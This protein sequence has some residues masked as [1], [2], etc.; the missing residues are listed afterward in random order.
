M[1]KAVESRY[2]LLYEYRAGKFTISAPTRNIKNP[3]D[4][5]EFLNGQKR[6]KGMTEDQISQLR[7]YCDRRW[8]I[9]Q[10]LAQD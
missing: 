10:R 3:K 1:R 7:E 9:L 4:I 5:T 6:F 8:S 2:W